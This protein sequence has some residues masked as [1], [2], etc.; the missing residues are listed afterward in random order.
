M[1]TKFPTHVNFFDLARATNNDK[2]YNN[3]LIKVKVKVLPV[4]GH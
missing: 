4:T 3:A 2:F 1:F